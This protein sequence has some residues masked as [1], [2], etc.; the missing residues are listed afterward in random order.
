MTRPTHMLVVTFA[1][2][3]GRMYFPCQGAAD[4][5]VTRAEVPNIVAERNIASMEP[6]KLVPVDLDAAPA[7]ETRG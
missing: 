4:L 7:E 6:F 1:D 5:R 3:G 2:D